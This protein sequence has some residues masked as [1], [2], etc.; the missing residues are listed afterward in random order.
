MTG[1]GGG[2]GDEGVVGGVCCDEMGGVCRREKTGG[3]G[4]WPLELSESER[5]REECDGSVPVMPPVR[6]TFEEFPKKLGDPL[7]L[8]AELLLS[9]FTRV[10][11]L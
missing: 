5:R 4:G 1:G 11:G 3:D 2:W 10:K 6:I 7:L 8:V 9:R